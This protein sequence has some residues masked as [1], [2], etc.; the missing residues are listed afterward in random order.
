MMFKQYK[1]GSCDIEFSKE[2]INI[3]SNKQKL[4]LSSEALHHFSNQFIKICF[5]FKE[6]EKEDLKTK[7]TYDDTEIITK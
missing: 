2:E 7:L 1:D 6:K 3:L 5:E 4:H